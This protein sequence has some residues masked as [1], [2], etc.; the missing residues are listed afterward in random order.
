MLSTHIQ[1]QRYERRI[2]TI[3][4]MI[5]LKE[6]DEDASD[7]EIWEWLKSL[8]ETLGIEGVSSDESEVD[9]A[10]GDEV[11]YV[12]S[13]EWRA[14]IDNEVDIVERQRR[15]DAD[16]FRTKGVKPVKRV[17]GGRKGESRRAAPIMKP[18]SIYDK[19]WLTNLSKDQKQELQIS[20]ERFE[21]IRILG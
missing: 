1:P 19:T 18:K 9:E 17:R 3:D 13:M 15:S 6:E 11:Y 10:T 7:L 8:F 4:R 14:D 20:K 2:K 12:K 5:K 16:I 21:W